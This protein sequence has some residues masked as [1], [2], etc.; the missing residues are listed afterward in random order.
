MPVLVD[1]SGGGTKFASVVKQKAVPRGMCGSPSPGKGS[2][3]RGGGHVHERTSTLHVVQYLLVYLIVSEADDA[4]T[5]A[6]GLNARRARLV[7][8]AARAR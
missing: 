8:T 6:G 2:M 5:R 3:I 7:G 1:A 4:A